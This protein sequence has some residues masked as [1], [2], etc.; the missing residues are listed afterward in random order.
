MDFRPLAIEGVMHHNPSYVV[1]Y[2][3]AASTI[4]S[5]LN[6]DDAIGSDRP[7]LIVGESLLAFI[8][9]DSGR[10]QLIVG[11]SLLAFIQ[12]HAQRVDSGG[13]HQSNVNIID[14]G[15]STHMIP[16]RG[17]LVDVQPS[18]GQVS[19]GDEKVK[20]DIRARGHSRL[21]GLGLF[22]WVPPFTFSLISIFVLDRIGCRTYISNGKVYVT[23][24]EKTIL[25]GT[26]KGN[27]Y[28]LDQE[29]CSA[30]TKT[31]TAQSGRPNISA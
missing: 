28:Y 19:L 15:A 6:I 2:D 7:H 9:I 20:L 31:V 27:L 17:V 21:P 11:A 10:P 8:Q 18:E 26:L 29:F 30:G 22:S 14:S 4:E 16:L 12:L 1:C 24:G 25:S 13:E 5:H 3:E 23:F